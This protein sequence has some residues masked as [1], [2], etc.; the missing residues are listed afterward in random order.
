MKYV[1]AF[2]FAFYAA[3]H[4][5]PA[6]LTFFKTYGGSSIDGAWSVQQTSDSGYVVTAE[7][8]SFGSG[9]YNIKTDITGNVSWS[10]VYN[11]GYGNNVKEIPGGGY[12]T[13]GRYNNSFCLLRSGASGN[14]LWEKQYAGGVDME[15]YSIVSA[16]GGGYVMAGYTDV[17]GA[18]G[19][20]IYVV[21][22][23]SSGNT[24]WT[25]T[26]GG[27]G[28]EGLAGWGN[29]SIH[30][31]QAGG[32][33]IGG[34]TNS[35]GSGDYDVYMIRI[36]TAGNV[37]WSKTFGGAGIDRGYGN[38]INTTFHNTIILTGF[39]NS[40]GAGSNDVYFMEVDLNGNLLFSKTYGGAGDDVGSSVQETLDGGY[41]IGGY[42]NSFGAGDYDIYLLKISNAGNLLWSKTFGGTGSDR[43]YDLKQSLDSGY[44]LTG[45]ENSYGAGADDIFLLKTNASGNETCHENNAA[46]VTG[47]PSTLVT[48]PSTL[49]SGGGSY[50]LVNATTSSGC[51]VTTLCTT[52]GLMEVNEENE[53]VKVFPDPFTTSATFHSEKPF[54]NVSLLLYDITG[55][56]IRRMEHLSGQDILLQRENLPAG[57]YFFRIISGKEIIGSGK[58]M[59]G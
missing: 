25:K 21:R 58:L 45:Y 32:Y 17:I 50:T 7:T 35:F 30:K 59:A 14:L 11:N 52:A 53:P 4:P 40:F 44:I 5:L 15:G 49:V 51:T 48:S 10:R 12:I 8:Q 37:V 1:L 26:Y 6:Q 13:V 36:D 18:G 24:I 39:T 41:I 3:C 23:D 19:T 9:V 57:L 46:T 2:S 28:S 55:C 27:S 31:I 43:C 56:E 20:D 54:K 38:S 22:T 29:I 42:T 47:T 16:A 34:Y 33:V